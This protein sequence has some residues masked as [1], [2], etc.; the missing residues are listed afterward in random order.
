MDLKIE[1]ILTTK[2]GKRCIVIE[3][4]KY[5][6]S[7]ILQNK[8]IRFRCTNKKCKVRVLIDSHLKNIL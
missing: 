5:T 1:H 6:E 2:K 4:F 3:Q 7:N 8:T